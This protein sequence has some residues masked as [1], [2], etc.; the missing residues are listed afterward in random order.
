M[1]GLGLIVLIVCSSSGYCR[2]HVV[3]WVHSGREGCLGCHEREEISW[4]S[5]P[6]F[7]AS[8]LEKEYWL[9]G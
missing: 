2:G 8:F 1:G 5:S 3:G 7:S 6:F 9:V 4:G